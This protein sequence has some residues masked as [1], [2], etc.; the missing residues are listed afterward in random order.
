MLA[1]ICAR[2]WSAQPRV[3]P[4]RHAVVRLCVRLTSHTANFADRALIGLMCYTFARVSA[5]VHMRIE[6]YYENGETVVDTAP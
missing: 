2:H 6:D 1:E 4:Q 3:W 5:V